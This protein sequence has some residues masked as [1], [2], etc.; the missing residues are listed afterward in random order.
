MKREANIDA[1]AAG[2]S[3]PEGEG[4]VGPI[5]CLKSCFCIGQADAVPD[6]VSEATLRGVGLIRVRQ[7]PAAVAD[8]QVQLLFIPFR[9]DGDEAGISL[10][11]DP[12]A[13]G[14]L[15]QR[16]EDEGWNESVHE[17]IRNAL[18]QPKAFAKTL[19]LNSEVCPDEFELLR[20]GDLLFLD[21]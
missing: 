21:S 16:L 8:G 14:V 15:D 17:F 13:D 7:A 11:F 20:Q 18:F 2:G 6:G 5:Q 10:W 9:F 4:V 12:V 19:L 3:L 1:A